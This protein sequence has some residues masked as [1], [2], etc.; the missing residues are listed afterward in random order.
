MIL[1]ASVAS[2]ETGEVGYP[3]WDDPEYEGDGE[4]VPLGPDFP[5]CLKVFSDIDVPL[6]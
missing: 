6:V 5:P 4:C 1:A 2:V 3:A